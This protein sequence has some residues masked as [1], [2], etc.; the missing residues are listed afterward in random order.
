MAYVKSVT[1]ADG[2]LTVTPSVGDPVPY[3][4]PNNAV[5]YGLQIEEKDGV[6][7]VTLVKDGENS[8]DSFKLPATA[9]GFDAKNLTVKEDGYLYYGDVKTEVKLALDPT[10][11]IRE[12]TDGAG[13]IIAYTIVYNGKT[14]TL[15]LIPGKLQSLV[16]MP[17]FYYGGIEAMGAFTFEYK[18]LDLEYVRGVNLN[19]N[20]DQSDDEGVAGET[21]SVTPNLVAR[22]HLNPSNVSKD[23]LKTENMSFIVD[24]KNYYTKSGV[25]VPEIVKSDVDAKKGIL[26]VYANLAEGTIK[27]LEDGK[28]TVLALQVGTK[29]EAGDTLV[30]SDYAAIRK[31]VVDNIV[32]SKIIEDE[33]ATSCTEVEGADHL[34][35]TAAAA[36]AAAPQFEIAYNDEDG[37]DVAD[38]IQSHYDADAVHTIWDKEGANSGTVEKYGFKYEYDLIGYMEGNNKTSQSAHAAL[39]GSLLRAQETLNGEQQAWGAK[40]SRAIIGR[41]PLVRVTLV[42]TISHNVAAVGYIKFEIIEDTPAPS[43]DDFI[44]IPTFTFDNEYTVSCADEDFVFNLNWAQV[45]EQI[46]STLNLSKDEFEDLYDLEGFEIGDKEGN[47]TLTGN[48]ATQYTKADLSAT[49]VAVANA[50]GKVERT[51][52]DVDGNMTEVLQWTVEPNEAYENLVT[53]ESISVIVRFEKEN[54]NGTHH[55]VYVTFKWTPAPRNVEPAGAIDD[56]CKLTNYWYAQ[57]SPNGGLDEVHAH[58]AVPDGT[59]TDDSK[60]IYEKDL[61]DFFRGN[62]ITVDVAEPSVYEDFTDDKLVKTLKFIEPRVKMATGVSGDT[63]VLGVTSDGSALVAE[64]Y[65]DASTK[66]DDY[67]DKVVVLNG[68]TVE[69]QTNATALDILNYKGRNDL[70]DGE[71]LAGRIGIEAVN[72]CGKKIELTNNTFEVRFIRPISVDR[73]DNEGLTD[74]LDNGDDIELAEFIR[75]SDWRGFEFTTTNNYFVYYGVKA[76]NID[77]DA[78]TTDLSGS[79]IRKDKLTEVAPGIVIS[80]VAPEPKDLSLTN[81]GTLTYKNNS[82]ELREE[83]NISVPVEV[84]Y[85]WGKVVVPMIIT[86]HETI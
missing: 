7:T 12:V 63:Y 36:I 40:Q 11:D 25:V 20:K 26:T 34:Y 79:D 47:K 82:G 72:G 1:F 24:D 73:K 56:N 31:T 66:T 53:K 13:N 85:K 35:T 62:T 65:V 23:L 80:Y 2:V 3:T 42:D 16:F 18:A 44:A 67:S 68:T 17:D 70:A 14:T 76:I 21:A 29:G 33:E 37:V 10:L 27:T 30:T 50:L 55:Y 39:K 45:E 4:L 51:T 71:T 48:P 32:L 6:V 75:F 83:F 54:N 9:A 52:A 81:M 22:Y 59:I 19:V 61:L 60:C 28:V 84:T 78:I 64:K 58:V 74:G 5:V 57:A 43:K 15:Q 41:M 38:L 69:Y 8:S 86:V 46:Y 77:T 49:A